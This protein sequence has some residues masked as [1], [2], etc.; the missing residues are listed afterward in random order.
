MRWR[1][2]IAGVA[3]AAAALAVPAIAWGQT[4]PTGSGRVGPTV[5]R[6][7][8]TDNLAA[9]LAQVEGATTLFQLGPVEVFAAPVV[10]DFPSAAT[11]RPEG[12]VLPGIGIRLPWMI[13]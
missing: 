9:W 13:P 12:A 2:S 11:P 4:G 8:L 1:S 5:E 3:L 10:V 6:L 7:L